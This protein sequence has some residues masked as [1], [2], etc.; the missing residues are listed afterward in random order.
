MLKWL[1]RL[2][3]IFVALGVSLL[4]VDFLPIDLW[5][6]LHGIGGPQHIRVV[7]GTAVPTTPMAIVLLVVGI[8]MLAFTWRRHRRK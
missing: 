8:T 2:G 7:P 1:S 3:Y 4:L 6:Y 5:L